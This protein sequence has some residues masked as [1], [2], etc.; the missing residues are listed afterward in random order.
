MNWLGFDDAWVLWL[1]PL[2]LLPL[3]ASTGDSL[4]NG[5]LR[6]APRD[7]ASD[8]IGWLLRAATSIAI[9]ALLFA[10]AGPHRPEY[11]LTRIG[12]GAEIVLLLDRSRSMDQGFAP[13]R[14]PP[15]GLR[16]NSPEALDYAFSQAPARLREPKG[17]VARR[18]L[19][20]FTAQRP[21]DRF[22]L[23]T[24]S[25]L[26][27]R[28]LDFTARGDVIRAAI[29]AGNI[30]R[31]LA[32]TNIG[33]ALE[34]ALEMFDGRPYNG[35]RIVLLVSDGGDRIEPDTRERLAKLV[36]RERVAIYWIYLRSANSPGLVPAEGDSPEAADVV[37]ELVL[38]A[39]F[40]GLGIPY[41]AY[42]ASDSRALQRAIDDVDRQQKLPIA[43][44]ELVPQRDLAP[45]AHGLALLAVL[46]LFAAR[47]LEIRRW[48]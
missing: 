20:E 24:F 41:R 22:A 31:G 3:L 42:E 43:Y 38:H 44:D 13:G 36:R 12:R 40:N 28:V 2:A 25:T 23:I 19:A 9:G 35:S 47:S 7:R 45:W 30:G 4:A 14:T 1:W 27:M 46:L 10:L 26:P 32:E 6:F 29:D 15:P 37:P 5:W 33:R 11:H 21:Q 39:F 17:Q 8:A 34:V 48:A 18:M 16:P